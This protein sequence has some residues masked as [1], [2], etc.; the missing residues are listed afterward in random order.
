MVDISTEIKS[1]Q[2]HPRRTPRT[3]TSLDPRT[4]GIILHKPRM[5]NVAMQTCLPAYRSSSTRVVSAHL[6]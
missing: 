5:H 2:L 3:A 6:G 4:R 1:S